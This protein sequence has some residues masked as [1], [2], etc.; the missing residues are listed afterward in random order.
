MSRFA[1]IFVSVLLFAT[2]DYRAAYGADDKPMS[3]ELPQDSP[4]ETINSPRYFADLAIS[5]LQNAKDPFP[6]RQKIP[7]LIVAEQF[8]QARIAIDELEQQSRL[9]D[10]W[11]AE[12]YTIH[13]RSY[14]DAKLRT[15]EKSEPFK[16]AF[17]ATFYPLYYK[18]DKQYWPY[19]PDSFGGNAEKLHGQL[20][21]QLNDLKRNDQLSLDDVKALTLSYFSWYMASVIQPLALELT[22]REEQKYWSIEDNLLIKTRDDA[23]LHAS[24][25][26]PKNTAKLPA[27]LIYNIYAGG[28]GIDQKIKEAALRG[29]VGVLVY[30]RG[31][32]IGTGN[33]VPFEHEADDAYD[34]IEW[35]TRQ[36]W[37]NGKVGMYG[38]SYLGFAQWAATKH[39]HPALKTI[40]PS[41][42]IVPGINDNMTE[43]SVLS[44][45]SLSWFHL[46]GND[47]WMDFNTYYDPRW[48]TLGERWFK[49]GSAFNTLDHMDGQPTPLFQ[50]WLSHPHYDA[51]W[52]RMVP[53]QREFEAINIPVLSITGYFDHAQLG[54]LYYFNEHHKYNADAEHYLLIGPFDHLGASNRARPNVNG[55]QIDPGAHMDLNSLI[56]DWLDYVLKEAEKPEIIKDKVNYQVMG[57]NQWKHA[58]SLQEAGSN[59]LSF[60]LSS[61]EKNGSYSLLSQPMEELSYLQQTVNMADKNITN[62]SLSQRALNDKVYVDNGFMFVSEPFSE[63]TII[64]GSFSGN[65]ELS[66]NKKDLDILLMLYEQLDN[67]TFFKLSHYKGR[68][69]YAMDRTTRTLLIPGEKTTIAIR[70]TTMTSRKLSKNSRLLIILNVNKRPNDQINYG[71]GK[72]VSEETKADAGEPLEVK[73]FTDSVIRL[74]IEKP[75]SL[76]KC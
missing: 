41:A 34:I 12:L 24:V 70:N 35:I 8:Q 23:L 33:V 19:I 60:Y 65:L 10:P 47:N 56:Y 13:Y 72:P 17:E 44:T 45:D 74:P 53:Y 27:V 40:V 5:I 54:T 66:I 29:Y 3:F 16:E 36:P 28:W 61:A 55:Y 59:S 49:S 25:A 4:V 48:R 68:A 69:S 58:P 46:V 57:A 76:S 1:V 51:Y 64:S 7:L 63:P 21:D 14:V 75:C 39:L 22:K 31:K 18:V 71:S 20:L 67:G 42:A 11:V 32:G 6:L 37:S 30:G 38:G 15:Q 2:L 43:N 26:R 62:D 52:Q 9:Q 50:R 73:W